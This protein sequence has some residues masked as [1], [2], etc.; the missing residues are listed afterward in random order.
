M[1]V[2]NDANENKCALC[3]EPMP[4]GETMFK[5]HGYSGPCPKPAIVKLKPP[6]LYI[7]PGTLVTAIGTEVTV[8]FLT[9]K[10]SDDFIAFLQWLTSQT[11]EQKLT[12]TPEKRVEQ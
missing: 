8:H 1:T 6:R 7:A 4:E 10:E 2:A 5:Y 11:E 9:D 3:G 12:L